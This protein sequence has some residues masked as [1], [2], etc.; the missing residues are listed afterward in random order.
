M[1]MRTCLDIHE[2]EKGFEWPRPPM[3]I[4]G[5]PHILYLLHVD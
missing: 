4:E 3:W 5:E 2:S 1:G